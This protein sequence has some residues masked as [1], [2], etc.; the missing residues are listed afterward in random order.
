METGRKRGCG[1]RLLR[2]ALGGVAA[3]LLLGVGVSIWAGPRGVH[4]GWRPVV[5]APAPS[6]NV[7]GELRVRVSPRVA[8]VD[9]PVEITVEGLSPGE[10]LLVRASTDDANGVAFESWARFRADPGGRVNLGQHA[11]LEG[12]YDAADASG[13][14]WSMRSE[15]DAAFATS[16][17]W[18]RRQVA[19]RFETSRGFVE[20][21][22]ERQYPWELTKK[23]EVREPGVTAE[24]W[25]PLEETSAPMQ[26][27]VL[28]GGFGDGPSPLQ[29]SLLAARGV[30]ALN[31]GYHAW[32]GLSPDLVE[33]PVETV[34]RGIDWARGT[35]LVSEAPV[36]VLGAS[37]G[38]ELALVAAARD[39][40]IGP[41]IAWAPSSTV[42]QGISFRSATPGSSWTWGGAPVPYL[43][44]QVNAAT[45]RASTRLL[46]RRPVSFRSSYESAL[47]VGAVDLERARIE[48]EA[49]RG[50]FLL[51]AGA[52][53]QMWPSH[54]M[55]RELAD[56][57]ERVGR[58]NE[59]TLVLDDEAGHRVDFGLWPRGGGPTSF[60]IR[61][62]TP[63]AAHRLGRRAWQ[64]SLDLLG[65]ARDPSLPSA[66]ETSGER[67]R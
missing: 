53:D 41:V 3:L 60:F 15:S 26:L 47:D 24:L 54:R 19:L 51:A 11:P 40:R 43:A 13:L 21:T 52:D 57:L 35:G 5:P 64:A 16:A 4:D 12:S 59:V 20:E 2:L 39:P 25:T 27:V 36:A 23:R 29:A 61:G 46:L 22:I 62:G 42:F 55:A 67:L 49:A 17:A 65:V 45:L 8:L 30:A 56:S 31:L 32:P 48:V 10:E 66:A 6:A 34:S 28:L 38:A 9:V 58:R 50:P 7:P 14:L 33:V 37:K 63:E 44:P 18:K 1:G